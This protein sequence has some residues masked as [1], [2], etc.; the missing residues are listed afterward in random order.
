MHRLPI[1]RAVLDRIEACQNQLNQT[2][3][4]EDTHVTRYEAC[5][6]RD[7]AAGDGSKEAARPSTT[8][9]I[10]LASTPA[11][12]KSMGQIPA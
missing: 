10:R 11:A 5:V 4:T 2:K 1:D 9:A 7:K 8:I 12:P 3:C 6:E